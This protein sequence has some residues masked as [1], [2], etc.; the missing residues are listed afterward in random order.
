MAQSIHS[1]LVQAAGSGSVGG[2]GVLVCT[3][4]NAAQLGLFGGGVVVGGQALAGLLLDVA[5][6]VNA[7][8]AHL[9]QN[10]VNDH[11]LVVLVSLTGSALGDHIDIL[12]CV[13]S[14][15]VDVCG[16]VH[17]LTLQV[18]SSGNGLADGGRHLSFGLELLVVGQIADLGG[19]GDVDGLAADGL[20][21]AVHL[22]ALD[23]VG[24][25]ANIFQSLNTS[26]N[27]VALSLSFL[28]ELLQVLQAGQLFL[29]VCHIVHSSISLSGVI[30]GKY[31]T[32][33]FAHLRIGCDVN[34]R[35]AQR[36]EITGGILD[37]VR[38]GNPV[39]DHGEDLTDVGGRVRLRIVLR[40]SHRRPHAGGV[41]R[42]SILT[43]HA[44]GELHVG[45]GL[46]GIVHSHVQFL[47]S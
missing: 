18:V 16:G 3:F 11:V 15:Q 9:F 12:G 30:G 27:S 20:R 36:G 32:Q 33:H 35:S 25:C 42:K 7:P 19:H 37:G 44:Q 43:F 13:S 29:I 22:D 45:V 24:L 1:H 34:R 8:V 28:C 17:D 5:A 46:C 23:D 39:H 40:V 38:G 6:Q 41:K 10:A 4:L 14:L 26:S 31:F 47:P 2:M 21:R